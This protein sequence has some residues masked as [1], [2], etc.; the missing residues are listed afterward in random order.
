MAIARDLLRQKLR[1]QA[2]V[3]GGVPDA[4][5]AVEPIRL[6]LEEL[7]RAETTAQ[8]RSA[9]AKAANAYWGVWASIPVPWA[10]KDTGRVP[11]HWRAFGTRSS[12][13]TGSPRSAAGPANAILNYLYAIL[14]AEARIALLAIGFEP[15]LGV[16][17]VDFQARD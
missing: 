15:G 10:R 12:P 6:A 9:E 1:C 3:L 16:L 4:G 7:E 11:V 14:E 13:L 2:D 5:E 8:L 17:H